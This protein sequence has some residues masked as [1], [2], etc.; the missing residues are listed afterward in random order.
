MA[1]L[2][3]Q[4]QQNSDIFEVRVCV[5]AQH[6]EMLDQ[7]LDLFAIVP[8]YDL[9]VMQPNQDLSTITSIIIT[10]MR[11]VLL[12]FKP[13]L[14][15]VHGDTTT[16]FA[17]SLASFYQ[18]IPVGHVE[19]GLRTNNIY[20]PYPEE[21]N[22]Q[23]TGVISRYNFSP[24]PLSKANLIME[25]KCSDSILVTGNTVIDS[26]LFTLGRI[27]NDDG[28]ET[29]ILKSIKTNGYNI[30]DDRKIIL[31]TAHRRENHGLGFENIC[32]ALKEIAYSNPSVD[33]V[34]PVHL[35]PN[36]TSVANQLLNDVDNIFLIKPLSYE[37]FVYLMNKSYFLITDSGGIQE[38]APSLKKPVLVMRTSTERPEALEAGTIILVGSE[39]DKIVGAANELLCCS[40]SLYKKMSNS[41]NPYGDGLASQ[42]IVDFFKILIQQ[43]DKNV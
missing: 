11:G 32:R 26:L 29:S 8:E 14:V 35:N 34:F 43:Q 17:T 33:I 42:R 31:V 9:N 21:M 6:R 22:R 25:N 27:E 16:S 23:L 12:D 39:V 2:V 24:T 3:K 5:T 7:A 18:K 38:E 30:S 37:K 19:A 15:L 28:L 36:I 10:E 4:F 40:S 1:P 13:D 20:S 41:I